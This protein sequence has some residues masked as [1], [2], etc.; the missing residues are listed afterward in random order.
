MTESQQRFGYAASECFALP[1]ALLTCHAGFLTHRSS[2]DFSFSL[3]WV[4]NGMNEVLLPVYS[5]R[6]VQ[7]S[8]LIPSQMQS[9]FT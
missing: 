3:N 9:I 6:I 1:E 8:H 2:F 4:N 5:D 7:A